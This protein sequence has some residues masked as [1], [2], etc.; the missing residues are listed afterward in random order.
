MAGSVPDKQIVKEWKGPFEIVSGTGTL[1]E[2]GCHIHI[3]VSDKKGTVIGGHLKDGNKVK[4]TAEVVLG[5]FD[6]AV[7]TRTP[8]ENTGFEELNVHNI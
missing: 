5:V 7:Y 2:S 3:S 1:S 6:D 8:D 4:T